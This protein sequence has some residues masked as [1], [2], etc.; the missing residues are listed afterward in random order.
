MPNPT[1]PNPTG[2]NPTGPNPTGP[3]PT[4]A[5]AAGSTT[6]DVRRAKWGGRLRPGE[7][8][9]VP[10]ARLAHVFVAAGRVGMEGA[11]DLSVGDAVRLTEAGSPLLVA[12]DAPG[13]AEVL[14]WEMR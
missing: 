1:G 3:N 12:D 7:A 13:G 11:G 6:F 5:T 2:P 4:G 14:I 10:D 9:A 8:V